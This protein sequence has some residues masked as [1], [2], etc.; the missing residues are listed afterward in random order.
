MNVLVLING[1]KLSRDQYTIKDGAII[2]NF[3]PEKGDQI[4]CRLEKETGLDQEIEVEE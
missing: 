1:K 2:L 3:I 4:V